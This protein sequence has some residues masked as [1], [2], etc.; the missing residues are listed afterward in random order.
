MKL[1]ALLFSL[2]V[3]GSALCARPTFAT[4]VS[5]Y[6]GAV[7]AYNAGA[8]VTGL[9]VAVTAQTYQLRFHANNTASGTCA[10]YGPF[11]TTI[12]TQGF[13]ATVGVN[14]VSL[15]VSGTGTVDAII[16][17]TALIGVN[18]ASTFVYELADAGGFSPA[19]P[20]PY[21]DYPYGPLDAYV[22]EPEDGALVQLGGTL[23]TN[24]GPSV[25]VNVLTA[26]ASN[27]WGFFRVAS[28]AGDVRTWTLMHPNATE[29]GY[30]KFFLP[31]APTN[32]EIG[33]HTFYYDVMYGDPI[34][35]DD[36][37]SDYTQFTI[38]NG[39]GD[40]IPPP[41][42]YEAT[43]GVFEFTCFV[44]DNAKYLMVPSQQSIDYLIE[45][46]GEVVAVAPFQWVAVASGVSMS[47]V[48]ETP[49]CDIDPVYM[50]ATQI[51]DICDNLDGVGDALQANDNMQKIFTLALWALTLA[52]VWGWILAFLRF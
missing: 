25:V 31:W 36:D 22:V 2:V 15:V 29:D 42:C 17:D 40:P 45:Q 19:S 37:L 32:F 50:G 38:L 13:T 51:V 26:D 1:R 47:F 33:D 52:C 9:S 28:I 49:D 6:T 48:S 27:V 30:A 24:R 39:A 14:T 43:E 18:G 46:S 5:Q 20:F 23:M 3:V 44:V 11:P 7:T 8:S 41:D 10:L 34:T 12:A 16:C 4:T 21:G 35:P